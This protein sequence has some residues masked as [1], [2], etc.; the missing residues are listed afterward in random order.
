MGDN[1]QAEVKVTTKL[2]GGKRD[3]EREIYVDSNFVGT[4]WVKAPYVYGFEPVT[5]AKH[6]VEAF[7]APRL[8][9]I[10][11]IIAKSV[12]TG[13]PTY[14]PNECPEDLDD[15]AWGIWLRNTGRRWRALRHSGGNA[16][17]DAGG[18]NQ[19]AHRAGCERGVAGA[20]RRRMN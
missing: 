9:D 15:N 2:I 11:R 10:K 18:R 19:P 14:T 7:E 17:G 12:T 16:Q 3:R 8:K 6:E 1:T 4:A 20:D 13:K 5:D